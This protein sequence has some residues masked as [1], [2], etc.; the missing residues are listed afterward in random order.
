MSN[1]K[2]QRSSTGTAAA[3]EL[4]ATAP[5]VNVKSVDKVFVKGE[6]QLTALSDVSFELRP[7]EFIALVGPSGCGK[8]TLLRIIAGLTRPTSG[9]VSV[10]EHPVDGPRRDVGLMFQSPTL[11]EWRSVLDNVLLPIELDHKP[12][13]DDVAKARDLLKMTGLDGFMDHVPRELSGGMQQRAALSRV[14]VDDPS[15][16]LLD[17]PFGALDEFTRERLN[18]ELSAIVANANAAAVLVTH[19]IYEAIFLA[20][21]VAAMGTDPGRIVKI[22]DVPFERPRTL[23][24]MRTGEF[25]NMYGEIRDVLDSE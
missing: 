8:S 23:S 2:S 6:S 13:Y 3:S 5:A 20:D 4:A 17:E 22:F 10:D 14:L 11:F 25:Q 18:L 1:W 12:T 19:S 21:R 7:R 16:M 15:L 24:L 9:S